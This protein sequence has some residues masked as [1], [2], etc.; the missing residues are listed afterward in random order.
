M[1]KPVL[2]IRLD[3]V[4]Q[5]LASLVGAQAKRLLSQADVIPVRI[6]LLILVNGN[7]MVRILRVELGMVV[8][9][10]N[11]ESQVLLAIARSFEVE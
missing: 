11:A 2:S 8:R 3:P 4:M 1:H 5:L 7:Y 6:G 10:V 9:D